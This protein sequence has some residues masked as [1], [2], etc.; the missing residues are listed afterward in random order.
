[1]GQGLR[2]TGPGSPPSPRRPGG[3]LGRSRGRGR[4]RTP[5]D[6]A[7]R[8][9]GEAAQL[10]PRAGSPGAPGCRLVRG[11]SSGRG[12]VACLAAVGPHAH[13]RTRM[14]LT[15]LSHSYPSL[16]LRGRGD[17]RVAGRRRE[18]AGLRRRRA[19]LRPPA[20][21]CPARLSP[22]PRRGI[23]SRRPPP[24]AGGGPTFPA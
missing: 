12:G 11:G 1:M 19:S 18:G 16:A 3:P 22:T 6:Q 20:V 7:P 21:V 14:V 8:A 9:G 2:A 15:S 17:P 5:G 4:L 23:G 24:W 10:C 13:S